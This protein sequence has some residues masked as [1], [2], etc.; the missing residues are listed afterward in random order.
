MTPGWTSAI[1]VRS[2][3]GSGRGVPA[4]AAD[5]AAATATSPA[6]AGTRARRTATSTA[7]ATFSATTRKLGSHTPP[8][9]AS[10]S[11]ASTCHWLAPSTPHGPP[12]PCQERIS[13]IVSQPDGTTRSAAA[14]RPPDG[15]PP[16]V[17][18][19]SHPTA[20]TARPAARR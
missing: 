20:P 1:R 19:T 16:S 14:T 10:L 11:A 5:P 6:T 4:H 15:E 18:R 12:S 13:S 7:T 9:D 17:R 3:V 8:T 2:P